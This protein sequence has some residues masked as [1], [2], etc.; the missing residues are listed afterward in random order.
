MKSDNSAAPAANPYT[1]D[2]AKSVEW[3]ELM[4]ATISVLALVVIYL[5]LPQVEKPPP[6][7][8]L[9]KA[10]LPNAITALVAIPVVLIVLQRA[11][12]SSEQKMYRV[13]TAALARPVHVQHFPN[14]VQGIAPE[15]LRIAEALPA[16]QAI[17]VRILAYTGATFTTGLLRDLL[18]RFTSRVSIELHVIDFAVLDRTVF[19]VH[20]PQEVTDTRKRLTGLCKGVAQL[21]MHQYRHH[22]FML[23]LSVNDE[24]LF[25]AFPLWAAGRN[26]IADK[27]LSYS[28]HRRDAEGER[29]FALFDTW[30]NQPGQQQ[31]ESVGQV[32]QR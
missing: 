25:V 15:V 2:P 16:N 27:S 11:G 19:P 29:F 5:L 13:M 14:D 12:L 30:I 17:N 28:Y 26:Q 3:L 7:L 31:I 32:P 22:P 8:E 9:L 24:H 21:S 6:Y 4:V 20:W 18:E 10:C 23:G 1:V